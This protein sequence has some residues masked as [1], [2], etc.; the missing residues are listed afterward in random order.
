[1]SNIRKK[2]MI[3]DDDPTILQMG[4]ELLGDSFDV[5]PLPSAA[6]MF[7]ALGKVIPDLF[8]LD[9]NMPDT[10][11]FEIIMRLKS[12]ARYAKIPVIFAT[13][14]FTVE[15]EMEGLGLGAVDFFTK[16]FKNPDFTDRIK[17][18]LNNENVGKPV[19][20]AVD[21]S[22][23][24]L[25]MIYTV[26]YDKYKVYTLPQPRRFKE[27]LQN[28]TPDL[29]LLDYRM[30]SIT[31]LDLIP[32]IRNFPKHKD[33]PIIFLTSDGR[34][35]IISAAVGAGVCD[36]ILKPFDK[37]KKKKKIAQHIVMGK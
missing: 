14:L 30:P 8:L 35:D 20:L 33:T 12:E 23:D 24:I 5:Y 3:V 6:K 4:K 7:L 34:F 26:L 22:P 32:I 37:E 2:I 10:D 31:G 9:I 11:G 19:I 1:M 13:G 29:F 27:F 25:K 18:H 16:P 21:D 36:Y 17:K 15:R 28:I